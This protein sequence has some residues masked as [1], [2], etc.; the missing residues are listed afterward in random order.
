MMRFVAIT[1]LALLL[2]VMRTVQASETLQ[3]SEDGPNATKQQTAAGDEKPDKSRYLLAY[4]FKPTQRVFYDVVQNTEITTQRD[5]IVEKV[6]NSSKARKHYRVVTIV[7]GTHGILEPVIDNVE[8]SAQF[9]DN[10]PIRYDSKLGNVPPK[11]FASIHKTIGKPRTRFEFAANGELIE[12]I[13]LKTAV[14]A[15]RSS[16]AK[17]DPGQNFL[18]VFPDQ[19]IGIGHTWSDKIQVKV[20][21]SKTLRRRMTLVREYK[22]ESVKQG[23]AVISL[24]TLVLERVDDPMIRAQLIQLEPKGTIEFDLEQGLIVKRTLD[25]DGMVIG[26]YGNNSS[27]SAVG[28]MVERLVSPQKIAQKQQ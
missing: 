23:K 6:T 8:M 12:T 20:S 14:E 27:M 26:I 18:I 19:P 5:N 22:L 3:A 21:V 7:K 17:N 11:E 24:R 4:Q 28:H 9:G 13:P 2:L 15:D 25:T 16:A 10:D 1:L